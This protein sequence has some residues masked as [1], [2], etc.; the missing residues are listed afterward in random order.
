MGDAP[1][2]VEERAPQVLANLARWRDAFP[3]RP[4]S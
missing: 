4:A 3:H 1:A 2:F